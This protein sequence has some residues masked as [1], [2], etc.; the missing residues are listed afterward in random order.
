MT[1]IDYYQTL[2]VAPDAS[3]ETIKKAYR[4]L[5][6]QYHPDKNPNNPTAYAQFQQISEAYAVLSE[7]Q[8]RAEYDR[9]L[10][11]TK[12]PIENRGQNPKPQ[13]ES[14]SPHRPQT[15]GKHEP[16]HFSFFRSQPKPQKDFNT[17]FKPRKGVAFRLGEFLA[18]LFIKPVPQ[19]PKYAPP[20]RGADLYHELE[21][22][23]Y[24]VAKG[25]QKEIAVTYE[26]RCILCSG[27]GVQR[28]PSAHPFGPLGAGSRRC[29]R[30]SGSGVVEIKRGN[31]GI[32]QPCPHCHGHGVKILQPCSGCAGTGKLEKTRPVV[33]TV[34]PGIEEGTRLK[35]A[36]QGGAGRNGGLNGDMYVIIKLKPHP[37]V[38][39]KGN[40]LYCEV[41]I[42]FVQAILGTTIKLPTLDGRIELQVPPGVQPNQSLRIR[43]KGLPK[44]N[45]R[46]VGDAYVKLKILLPAEITPR[47]RELLEQFYLDSE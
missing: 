47:Q 41:E 37:D 15:R 24:E 16:I 3:V 7:S 13:R 22:T 14:P 5:A 40:D 1:Q 34:E 18:R 6:I 36:K 23:L 30:C 8:K 4:R 45:G 12:S 32:K 28:S 21:L 31:F 35:V 44:R 27:T 2:D 43:G 29:S 42:D 17:K 33:I 38:V 20:I 9:K 10:S 11:A 26:E 46:E 39:R 19:K 25:T